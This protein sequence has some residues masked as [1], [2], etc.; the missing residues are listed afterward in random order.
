MTHIKID[1]APIAL[2]EKLPVQ[3]TEES[4]DRHHLIYELEDMLHLEDGEIDDDTPKLIRQLLQALEE[5]F[6]FYGYCWEAKKIQQIINELKKDN[7][8]A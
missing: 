8:D 4:P 2:L 6:R 7:R 1:N 5:V 3:E